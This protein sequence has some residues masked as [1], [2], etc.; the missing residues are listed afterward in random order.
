MIAS[1]TIFNE[2]FPEGTTPSCYAVRFGLCRLRIIYNVFLSHTDTVRVFNSVKEQFRR[3]MPNTG[4]YM[5]GSVFCNAA[6]TLCLSLQEQRASMTCWRSCLERSFTSRMKLIL[7][8]IIAPFWSTR[9]RRSWTWSCWN[10]NRNR[11]KIR[12]A[13]K[14]LSAQLWGEKASLECILLLICLF[15]FLVC[16]DLVFFNLRVPC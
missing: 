12:M 16:S 6:R 7:I 15:A 3:L 2:K 10:R 13:A 4:I 1:Y 8:A 9:W 14:V 11:V 5:S